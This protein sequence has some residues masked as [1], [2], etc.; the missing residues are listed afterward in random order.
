MPLTFPSHAAAVLPLCGKKTAWLPP[1]ALVIGSCAPDFAYLW[2]SHRTNFHVWPYC[3]VLC[4]PVALVFWL[5]AELL[6]LPTLR[7]ALPVVGG[8]ELGRFCATRPLRKDFTGALA[9]IAALCIGIATHLLWDGCTHSYRF[10]ANLFYGHIGWELNGKRIMAAQV[11]QALSSV[12]GAAIVLRWAFRHY[13]ELP[14]C[15]ETSRLPFAVFVLMATVGVG[16]SMLELASRWTPAIAQST[17]GAPWMVF[18][19]LTRGVLL[20]LLAAA[21]AERL[22]SRFTRPSAR[23]PPPSPA[24]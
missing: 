16:G 7:R 1:S 20:G 4:L 14:A 12:V 15:T 18:W 6:V 5:L 23:P 13:A 17:Y 11:L 3:L 2:D 8:V 9:V 24:R 22:V 10:P 19:A 21:V